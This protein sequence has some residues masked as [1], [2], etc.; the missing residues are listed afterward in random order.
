MQIKMLTPRMVLLHKR[1]KINLLG[2]ANKTAFFTFQILTLSEW[3]QSPRL[4]LAHSTQHQ[5]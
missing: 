3:L 1:L 2:Q 4:G 5:T